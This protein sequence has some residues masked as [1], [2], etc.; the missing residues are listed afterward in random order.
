MKVITNTIS[1][2]I[3]ELRPSDLDVESF[4]QTW[5]EIRKVYPSDKYEIFSIEKTQHNQDKVFVEL[6]NNKRKK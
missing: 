2:I 4:D 5:D 6:S 3:I 1:K